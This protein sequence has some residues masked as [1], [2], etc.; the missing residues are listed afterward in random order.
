MPTFAKTN[1]NRKNSKQLRRIEQ[2]NTTKYKA[3]VLNDIVS[4][5]PISMFFLLCLFCLFVR[6]FLCLLVYLSSSRVLCFSD[7]AIFLPNPRMEIRSFLQVSDASGYL[8]FNS[9]QIR[10]R[11]SRRQLFT[12]RRCNAF[13][14]AYVTPFFSLYL[15][16]PL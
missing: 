9:T 15:D 8:T 1:K 6:F 7:W 5:C 12:F 3:R 14:E 4:S 11:K 10:T 13:T 2:S 16:I